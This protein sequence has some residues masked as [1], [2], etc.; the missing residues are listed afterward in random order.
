M[1]FTKKGIGLP[2][3]APGMDQ[4]VIISAKLQ[5]F[6][7]A[8]GA[9]RT[10]FCRRKPST[11]IAKAFCLEPQFAERAALL[12]PSTLHLL[13]ARESRVC[14]SLRLLPDHSTSVQV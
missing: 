13:A 1:I 12:F 3:S 11:R 7:C 6:G 9:S 14:G 8:T 5:R 4:K 10:Y 2:F